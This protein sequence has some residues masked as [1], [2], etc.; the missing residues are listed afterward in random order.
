MSHHILPRDDNAEEEAY[1]L[2]R[3]LFDNSNGAAYLEFETDAGGVMAQAWSPMCNGSSR[4]EIA[5]RGGTS[6][7]ATRKLV[8]ALEAI[9]HAEGF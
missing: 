7:E 1:F 6:A 8:V 3:K 5:M 4:L 9:W 2:A